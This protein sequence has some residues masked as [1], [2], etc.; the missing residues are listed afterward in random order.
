MNL[1]VLVRFRLVAISSLVGLVNCNVYPLFSC[2]GY[3]RSKNADLWVDKYRPRTL[4]ELAV[5][6]KKV[7]LFSAS[8]LA[9]PS[10]CFTYAYSFFLFL[11]LYMCVLCN[12]QVEEVKLWFEESFNLSKVISVLPLQLL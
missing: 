8:L 4:E 12:L 3:E 10:P 5:H 2:L 6:K 9:M 11:Y 7:S 1:L